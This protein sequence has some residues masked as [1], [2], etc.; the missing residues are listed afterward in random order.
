MT[1][2]IIGP[3]RSWEDWLGMAAGLVIM[4]APWISGET[5]STPAVA[6]A[7]LAGVAI[8]MLAELDLVHQRRWTIICQIACG[9]WV[10]SS[11]LVLDYARSGTLRFWHI[12]AGLVVAVLGIL[13]LRQ[14]ADDG[15]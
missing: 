5:A 11:P 4:L 15:E 10:A 3:H 7:A 12:T 2:P 6:N 1:K 13:E 8:L 9:L 14:L